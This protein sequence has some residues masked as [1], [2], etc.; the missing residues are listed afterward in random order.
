MKLEIN[1]TLTSKE[2]LLALIKYTYPTKAVEL[3]LEDIEIVSVE[4]ILS[5]NYNTKVKVKF[6]MDERP[7][8]VWT[9]YY[10]R[11]EVLP[12]TITMSDLPADVFELQSKLSDVKYTL[13]DVEYSDFQMGASG[14]VTAL[15]TSKP[16]SITMSGGSRVTIVKGDVSPTDEYNSTD[17]VVTLKEE[18]L[19]YSSLSTDII[20]EDDTVLT[21]ESAGEGIYSLTVP[22]GKYFIKSDLEERGSVESVAYMFMGGD[23]VIENLPEY[24][25]GSS[26][27]LSTQGQGAVHVNCNLPSS[28]TSLRGLFN[29]C[30]PMSGINHWDT[31]NVTDMSSMISGC[32]IDTID[33]SA[34]DVSNVTDVSMMFTVNTNINMDLSE[35]DTSNVTTMSMMFYGSEIDALT[36]I[37][38]PINCNVNRMLGKT[39]GTMSGIGQWDVSNITDFSNMWDQSEMDLDLSA[40]D[41]SNATNMHQMFHVCPNF[42][43][44]GLETWDVSNVTDMEFMFYKCPEFNGKIGNWNVGN[45]T[46][47]HSIVTDCSSLNQDFSNWMVPYIDSSAFNIPTLTSQVLPLPEF[48]KLP[49]MPLP[50]EMIDDSTLIITSQNDFSSFTIQLPDKIHIRQEDGRVLS[51]TYIEETNMYEYIAHGELATYINL[52]ELTSPSNEIK[53]MG[54]SVT[55]TRLPSANYKPRIVPYRTL[56]PLIFNCELPS[57][58]TDFGN[59]FNN[60]E[61]LTIVGID[62]WNTSNITSLDNAFTNSVSFN[63][64][65]SAWDVSNVTSMTNAFSGCSKFNKDLSSWCVSEI[66]VEPIDFS[67]D[68]SLWTL[69]KPVWGTCPVRT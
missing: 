28:Y 7:D 14:E 35:W 60:M 15:V 66:P 36:G 46:S 10:N 40:W 54:N 44:D 17:L 23:V 5:P 21:P 38:I 25:P 26:I 13:G 19:Y 29:S 20:T 39:S 30:G 11:V 41:V 53:V 63:S 50:S 6:S 12:E 32:T 4:E 47:M 43:G 68:T 22:A 2:N 8:S 48:R 67:K 56:S 1:L 49:N 61:F 27:M 37:Q 57:D 69:P 16:S 65:L 33:L 9:F 51:R 3:T 52:T 24:I 34:W 45:V 31:S 58:Y 64:N 62:D 42:K 55:V 59:M 18:C